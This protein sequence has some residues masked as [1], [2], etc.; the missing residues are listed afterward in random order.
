MSSR[1]GW[2]WQ[3][4]IGRAGVRHRNRWAFQQLPGHPPLTWQLSQKQAQVDK[5]EE[6]HGGGPTMFHRERNEFSIMGPTHL[7]RGDMTRGE[8][9]D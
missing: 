9:C 1:E 2:V 7:S 3:P 5:R 8:L 6:E 4:E